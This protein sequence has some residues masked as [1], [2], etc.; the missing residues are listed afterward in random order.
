MATRDL[1]GT[2]TFG[3]SRAAVAGMIAVLAGLV[4]TIVVAAAIMLGSPSSPG[5]DTV[6]PGGN[7]PAAAP[8]AMDAPILP[9]GL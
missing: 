7:V 8:P 9:P 1:T 3:R 2:T 4:A 6:N 5:T